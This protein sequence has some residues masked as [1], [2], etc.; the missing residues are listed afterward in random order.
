MLL[1]YYSECAATG[2]SIGRLEKLLRTL[3]G[4]AV[5][6]G[7]DFEGATKEDLINLVEGIES[8]DYTGW[9]KYD[10]KMILKRFYKWLKGN[11]KAYPEEVAWI[12]ANIGHKNYL[13]QELLTEEDVTHLVEKA[14]NLRDKALILTLY[15]SGCRIGEIAS[16]RLRNLDFDQYGAVLIVSGKTG[17]RRIRVVN[18]A[19]LLASWRDNHPDR[20]DPSA[21]LWVGIG[22]RNKG[23]LVTYRCLNMV[24]KRAARRAGLKKQV[25]PHMFRHSRAT[26][27]AKHLTE[28][29]L[30]QIFGWS[31]TSTMPARYVHL[32][33]RDT[34]ESILKLYGLAQAK[35]AQEEQMKPQNCP[36]CRFTNS[37]V[38]EFCNQCGMALH[39]EAAVKLEAKREKGDD[40]LSGLMEDSEVQAAVKN[41]ILRHKPLLERLVEATTDSA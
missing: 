8:R 15:E 4:I 19:P 16:L 14:D 3:Y 22:T 7:K 20:D 18:A 11:G 10:H 37:S 1:R 33:G 36:R 32:S 40:L 26:F 21:P 34:D 30:K 39:M 25:H 27:L 6:L 24:I 38:A 5:N 35:E 12:N 29:Q 2:Y 28:A 23:H 9:T 31:Q 41:A 13:P 17:D